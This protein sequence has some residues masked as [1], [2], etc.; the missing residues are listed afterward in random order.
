TAR[1]WSRAIYGSSRALQDQLGVLSTTLQEDLAGISVVKGYTLE[2]RRHEGFARQSQAYLDRALALAR[3][4]G[5]LTPL[6]AVIAA[7]GTLIVLWAGGREVIAGRMTLGS[8]V[9]FNAY[10]VYLSFP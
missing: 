3:A 2:Q 7:I 1:L 9:A 8:M 5:G 6:F 4:R 10:V